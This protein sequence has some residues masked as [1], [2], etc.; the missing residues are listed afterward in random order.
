MEEKIQQY[1]ILAVERF[2]NGES[3]EAICASL[4]KSRAWL[5]GSNGMAQANPRGVRIVLVVHLRCQIVRRQRLKKSSRWCVSTSIIKTFSVAPK[6]SFG[7]WKT[8]AFKTPAILADYQPYSHAQR[9]YPPGNRQIRGQG[10]T[11]SQIA[12]AVA[13]PDPSS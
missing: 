3:T 11:L 12:V 8:S 2:K 9:T 5:N 13:Q 10:N 7:N 6:P 4:G 1:R